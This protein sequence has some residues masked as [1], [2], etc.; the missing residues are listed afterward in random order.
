[1]IR[2]FRVTVPT[3]VFVLL[4]SEFVLLTF[5]YALATYLFLQVDPTVFLWDDGGLPRILVVVAS[6]LFGLHFLDLYSDIR[7]DSKVALTLEIGQSLGFAFLTQALLT[8]M[9]KDWMLPRWVMI[10]G[11]AFAL[12]SVSSWRIIYGAIFVRAFRAQRI[13]FLGLNPVVQQIAEYLQHHPESGYVNLGYLDDANEPG[14]QFYGSR[15]LGGIDAVNASVAA[16]KPDRIVV[17]MTERRAKMPLQ[18]LLDLRFSGI[19]IE[20]ASAAY[21]EACG[22]VCTKEL[23]PAQLIFS[24][25]LG[26]THSSV[27]LQSFY[28]PALAL[29]GTI[30]TLPVMLLAAIA[31]RLTSRGPI[32]YRQARVGQNGVPF[33]LYKFRSMSVDAEATTGAIWATKN[34][35]RVTPL[36]RW[37]R[38][39]RIDELPQLWNVLRGEM[40]IV[41]PRPERP[42]FV[43]VL[44]DRIPYY[45]QRHC[46]KPG[47]TGWA[48]INH[49]YGDTIEDTIVK[50]EF[51]LYYIKHMS[52]SLDLYIIFHT[53]KTMLR[54][55]GAQ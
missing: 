20:E 27:L 30:L 49:K 3:S 10:W 4:V 46:V 21:E 41:G 19:R 25:E 7:S 53:L 6:I 1:M 16:Q 18:E 47:I 40:S 13:L 2:L 34:D 28:S 39:L 55:R 37:L 8:Y 51:D 29:V 12:I 54:S 31:V 52:M 5:C 44:S 14:T 36:G 15:V 38:K 48:Q 24:G 45:R 9:D 22:R 43:K 42:E 11:S 50:L 35:P 32:L 23:R 26:P 33:I 17:G